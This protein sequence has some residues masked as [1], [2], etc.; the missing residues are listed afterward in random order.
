[1]ISPAWIGARVRS[2]VVRRLPLP[3]TATSGLS[4]SMAVASASKS[5]GS[6][7][8]K[9]DKEIPL[10]TR[11]K[12]IKSILYDMPAKAQA[13]AQ[14][15]A[16]TTT[17]TTTGGGRSKGKPT[18]PTRKPA[19][20]VGKSDVQIKRETIERAWCLIQQ[21]Q[22]VSTMA[23]I[24]RKYGAMRAAVLH[25]ELLDARLYEATTGRP[26]VLLFPKHMRIPTD[27]PPASGWNT[28]HIVR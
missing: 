11:L 15:A 4:R 21:Q 23:G 10:D 16:T 17:T 14:A 26:D 3:G 8:T 19:V 1:M 13:A 6:G 25:L 20:Y 9:G 28:D 5:D 12:H 7:N 22:A 24:R 2:T 18:Q 27:S